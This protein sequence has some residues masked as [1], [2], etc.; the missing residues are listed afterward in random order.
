MQ[1]TIIFRKILLSIMTIFNKVILMDM[2]KIPAM[3]KEEYDKLIIENYMSRIA[4][5]GENHPYIAPFMYVFDEENEFLYFLS[6]KY[7][8]KR[9]MIDKNPRVAVEIDKYNEDMSS[10]K[11]VTLRGSIEEIED[12]KAD[13]EIKNKFVNMLKNK[14][15]SST[16]LAAL[17]YSPDNSIDSILEDNRTTVWKLIDVNK[18]TALKNP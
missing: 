12:A 14:G 11:F 3:S 2:V 10:Y 7:G 18:I 13:K 15:I 9:E 16:A 1:F 17:G 6:T 8:I 5:A 4:F